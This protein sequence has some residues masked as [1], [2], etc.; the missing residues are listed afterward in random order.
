MNAVH[1]LRPAM[2]PGLAVPNDCKVVR[3][4]PKSARTILACCWRRDAD[5]R[6]TCVWRRVASL[7]YAPLHGAVTDNNEH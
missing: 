6:L 5:G 2:A 1:N 3:L 7:P 4:C